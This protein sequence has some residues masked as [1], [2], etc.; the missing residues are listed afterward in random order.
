MS[1]INTKLD[2]MLE[3]AVRGARKGLGTGIRGGGGEHK[4]LSVKR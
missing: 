2:R 4:V 1:T 3:G